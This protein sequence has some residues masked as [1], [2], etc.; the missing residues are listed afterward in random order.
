MP[1]ISIVA[2]VLSL[3]MISLVVV[4]WLRSQQP[5]STKIRQLLCVYPLVKA[6]AS[7]AAL[8]FW[9]DLNKHGFTSIGYQSCY[10]ISF[11]CAEALFLLVILSSASGYG[12]SVPTISPE[13]W[14]IWTTLGIAVPVLILGSY[15]NRTL[16]IFVFFVWTSVLILSVHYAQRNQL[17]LKLVVS[18]ANRDPSL[19][20][21]S[22]LFDFYL[23]GLLAWIG[24]ISLFI[25]LNFVL[26][27][28]KQWISQ[29]GLD[30]L[31]IGFFGFVFFVLRPYIIRIPQPAQLRRE[32][33]PQF[34][35]AE[36]PDLVG[37]F[38]HHDLANVDFHPGQ[39]THRISHRNSDLSSP[40]ENHSM[41]VSMHPPSDD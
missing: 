8:I 34:F 19:E 18:H 39:H 4:Y 28:H 38:G 40:N 24:T 9:T 16:S 27:S 30:I 23:L 31:Q 12:L 41:E 20:K 32:Y 26:F 7:I 22:K 17:F 35:V 14:P 15:F 13:N 2:L 37:A 33:A 10:Y 3:A 36:Q 25:G 11:V 1:I 5:G 21:M 29:L 6:V